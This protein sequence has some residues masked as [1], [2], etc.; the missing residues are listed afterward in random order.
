MKKIILSVFTVLTFGLV[1]AQEI[2]YGAKAG[3]NI[4]TIVGDVEEDLESKVGFHLGG[5]VEFKISEKFSIQPELLYSQQGTKLEYTESDGFENYTIKATAKYDYLNI[6]VMAKYY[7]AN[8]FNLQAGP[9]IGFLVGAKDKV[10]VES[11][12]L[13]VD[14]KDNLNKLDFGLNFGAGYDFTNKIFAE[15]RYNLG[16]SELGKDEEGLEGKNSVFQ[17]SLG[18]KF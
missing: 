9:Q 14:A 15:V 13:E 10:E 7:V 1:N 4:A 18:F 2:N 16:L 5:F 17:I 6:P 3:L 11:I 8:G 12:A